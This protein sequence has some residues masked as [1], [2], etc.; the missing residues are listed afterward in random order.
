MKLLPVI[1]AIAL[2]TA[3]MSALTKLSV[4]ASSAAGAAGAQ[5]SRARSAGKHPGAGAGDRPAER[6]TAAERDILQAVSPVDRAG[7]PV[8]GAGR[9]GA[10][11]T[12]MKLR[13]NTS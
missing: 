7:P 10:R 12:S 4:T 6:E 5:A 8:R 1:S 2:T 3:S 9:P 13:E 11:E